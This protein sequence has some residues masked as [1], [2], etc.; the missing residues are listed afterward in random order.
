[1]KK[2]TVLLLIAA[3]FCGIFA[4]CGKQEEEAYVPTGNALVM[5]GEEPNDFLDNDEV[6]QELNLPLP[7]LITVVKGQNLPQ[8]PTIPG[9]LRG[10]A[11]EISVFTAGV[12]QA[13][14][15]RCGLKGSPTQVVR[16]FTPP[17][18]GQAKTIDGN[19][20]Q[21]ADQLAQ[22]IREVLYGTD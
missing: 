4:G 19:E 9:M 20:T 12:L 2:F 16:T 6:E 7:A 17:V 21:Q 14:T 18:R 13:D 10:R 1:M 22:V 3:I 5:E 11:A 15:E 8:L